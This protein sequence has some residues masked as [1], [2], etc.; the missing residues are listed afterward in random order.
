MDSVVAARQLLHEYV[1]SLTDDEAQDL[2]D[3][4][5]LWAE[6][7]DELSAEEDA[8]VDQAEAEFER[9][10]FLSRDAFLR[11]YPA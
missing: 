6:E 11:K 5:L 9:G 2:L 7:S 8:L 10:E 3:Q 1:D 4:V